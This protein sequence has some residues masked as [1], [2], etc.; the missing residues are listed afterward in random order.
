MGIENR[1][2]K[3]IPINVRDYTLVEAQNHF[4][5]EYLRNLL[6]EHLEPSNG[7]FWKE[8]AD[9]LA[10][11]M[12]TMSVDAKHHSLVEAQKHFVS[13]YLRTL[14]NERFEAPNGIFW[15]DRADELADAMFAGNE[16]V[17]TDGVEY[18]K[19]ADSTAPD[20]VL[21]LA[22][23]KIPT[24]DAQDSRRYTLEEAK[25]KLLSYCHTAEG[26]LWA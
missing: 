19:P 15:K 24:V 11:V 20:T 16:A 21:L 14:V 7:N 3:N 4:A 1:P 22:M 10:G 5:S 18:D 9:H 26:A 13:E 6:N 8:S 17:Q 25:S 2:Q 12:F 23:A